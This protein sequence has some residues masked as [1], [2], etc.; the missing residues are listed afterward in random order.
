MF[1]VPNS[2]LDSSCFIIMVFYG[3]Y[4]TGHVKVTLIKITP[5]LTQRQSR[6]P[7]TNLST[8][9][10]IKLVW[11]L[12]LIK[13][14]R[15]RGSHGNAVPPDTPFSLLGVGRRAEINW[16]PWI[17]DLPG[18]IFK[19]DSPRINNINIINR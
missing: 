16:L 9:Y 18:E 19:D 12:L 14:R 8:Y 10:K 7:R 17:L 1:Y 2:K 5:Y 15:W 13:G 3:Y 6:A 11:I 4:V